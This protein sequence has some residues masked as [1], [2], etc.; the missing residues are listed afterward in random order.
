MISRAGARALR[1]RARGK[2]LDST[3][4]HMK[5]FR[6]EISIQTADNVRPKA[7]D[8]PERVKESS[9]RIRIE[10]GGS[11]TPF[12]TPE[13][14]DGR[15]SRERI[16]QDRRDVHIRG[17]GEIVGVR[18]FLE[19]GQ[20]VKQWLLFLRRFNMI[21]ACG[22]KKLV[23]KRNL[24]IIVRHEMPLFLKKF[25]EIPHLHSDEHLSKIFHFSQTANESIIM[26]RYFSF[27]FQNKNLVW[28]TFFTCTNN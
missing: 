20:A 13:S 21:Q 23:E 9:G 18:I 4:W 15:K 5:Q 6:D 2:P 10:S 27:D 25:N 12:W 14:S 17:T 3:P 28:S 11:R 22:R 1:A 24:F 8:A 7:L 19:V 16:H 26:L